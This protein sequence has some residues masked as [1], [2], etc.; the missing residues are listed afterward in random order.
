VSS[1][2]DPVSKWPNINEGTYRF[3][4]GC[5][6]TGIPFPSLRISTTK[7]PFGLSVIETDIF[8]I[9]L[10]LIALSAAFTRI[11]SN[12]YCGCGTHANINTAA[13]N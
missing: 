8:V 3:S 13:N 12:I 4:F 7:L 11:S 2:L 9:D 1:K 5:I 10:L 6:W